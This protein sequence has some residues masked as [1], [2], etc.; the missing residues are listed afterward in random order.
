MKPKGGQLERLSRHPYCLIGDRKQSELSPTA[1][2]TPTPPSRPPTT[3]FTSLT[4]SCL[5]KS[6]KLAK[7]RNTRKVGQSTTNIRRA[8][9]QSVRGTPPP[10]NSRLDSGLVCCVRKSSREPL[11]PLQSTVSTYVSDTTC[12]GGSNSDGEHP[13][14]QRSACTSPQTLHLSSTCL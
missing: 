3:E 14:Y 11:K 10:L 6:S 7:S 1:S 8:R 2:M 9:S 13:G 5:A 12:T 4:R